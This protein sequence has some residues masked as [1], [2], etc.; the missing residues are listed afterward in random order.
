MQ[1]RSVGATAP[2]PQ[3]FHPMAGSWRTAGTP[4]SPMAPS[5]SRYGG[6][7]SARAAS[8]VIVA[9]PQLTDASIVSWTPDSSALLAVVAE[10]RR[11]IDAGPD[12]RE[13]RQPY[14]L[15]R[16][17]IGPATR[18]VPVSGWSDG[19]LRRTD[20]KQTPRRVTSRCWIWRPV[21]TRPLVGGAQQQSLSVLAA[22]RACHHVRQ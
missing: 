1:R 10:Q 20:W 9:P 13:D 16:V 5:T 8:R 19:R 11:P 14:A 3:L 22:G 15:A 21:S 17:F 7:R 6:P 18:R 2:G 4:R 12:Q